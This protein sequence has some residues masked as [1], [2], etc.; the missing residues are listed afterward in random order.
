MGQ[1][2][3]TILVIDASPDDRATI[4]RLLAQGVPASCQ[5]LDADR[6]AA[7]LRLWHE[8]QPDCVLIDYRLPDMSGLQVL[9]ALVEQAG[10]SAPVVMLTEMADTEVAVEALKLGAQDYLAK[11]QLTPDTL[12]RAVTHTCEKVRL[13]RAQR[14][15]LAALRASEERLRLALDAA[16]RGESILERYQLL[17][18]HTRDIVIFMRADGQI[19][20]ANTAAVAAYGY[21]RDTLVAMNIA[22]LRD[23]ESVPQIVPQLSQADQEGLLF[24]TVHRR[25]DGTTFPVEISA[26]GADIRGERLLLSIIRDIS[27][28][29][30]VAAELREREQFISAVLNTTPNLLYV[31][32]LVT[33]RNIFINDQIERLSGHTAAEFQALGEESFESL[34]HPLDQDGLRAHYNRLRLAGDDEVLEYEFRFRH[35]DGSWR[36]LSSR[37]RVFNRGADGAVQTVLGIA[38]DVT[39]RRVAEAERVQLL[40]QAQQALDMAEEAVRVRDQ[41]LSIAAHELKNPLTVLLGNTQ[42]LERRT[43][44]TAELSEREQRMLRAIREQADRLNELITTLFDVSRIEM[45]QLQL[46]RAPLDLSAL[47]RH[48]V[49]QLQPTLTRHTLTISGPTEP[50][51]IEGDALRL[52]QVVQNLLGNAIKYSPTGGP[53]AVHIERRASQACITVTDRGIGIPKTALPYLFRRFFR[54]DN[55]RRQQIAGTGVGLYVVKEIVSRHGGE[56]LV[57]STEGEGS[58]FTVCMPLQSTA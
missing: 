38:N 57:S 3:L 26:I 49:E 51:I 16:R 56:V 1:P 44:R 48:I 58:A 25:R 46:A 36:W 17:S 24:E 28:R 7:G 45:G 11:D 15:T 37:D 40:A 41:F 5:L 6:G 9:A 55:T 21:D 32:S 22:D 29:V 39:A 10:D 53:I 43:A 42:L 47:V 50:L 12:R 14:Q 31:H 18:E 27:E 4:R 13:Q 23:P 20:E 52:E 35:K 2:P 8:R 19:V 34:L 33:N 54:A 30:Q